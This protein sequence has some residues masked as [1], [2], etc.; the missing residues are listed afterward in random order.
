MEYVEYPVPT[1][2]QRHVQC[3]WTLRDDA[4]G[5]AVQT[6]YADGRCE[7]VAHFAG[8]MRLHRSDGRSEAQAAQLFAGQQRGPI[9][10]QA[11]GAVHC[12]GVRL[13]PAASALIAGTRLAAFRDEIPDLHRVD[14]AFAADFPRAA[15]RFALS[16]HND[17]LWRLLTARCRDYAL[18]TAVEAAVTALD[19]CHGDMPIAALTQASGLGLRSLQTRFLTCVGMTAKEYARVRRLHAVLQTLDS[20]AAPLAQ[21]A[22]SHGFADQAHATRDILRL[23]GSTPARLMRALRSHRDGDDT[24]HLA[25]AFVRGHAMG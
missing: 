22:A 3:V 21:I 5:A 14:A 2:L 24:L 1:A 16:T 12:L 7:L 18:D 20:D 8:T 4:P 17:A 13:A 10:L 23:T 15:H 11:R 19:A 9:R 6:V 25:A